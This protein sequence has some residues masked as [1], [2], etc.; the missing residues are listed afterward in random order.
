[1][2]HVAVNKSVAEAL[3]PLGKQQ[4]LAAPSVPEHS[5][6]CPLTGVLLNGVLLKL[7]QGLLCTAL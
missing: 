3:Y 6:L 1:M 5:N 4:K 7:L 2:G